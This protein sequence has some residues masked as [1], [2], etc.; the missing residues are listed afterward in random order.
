MKA[1]RI[2]S[3]KCPCFIV[4]ILVLGLVVPSIP[5]FA[6][7]DNINKEIQAKIKTM[8]LDTINTVIGEKKGRRIS[9]TPANLSTVAQMF[10]IEQG[11][12]IGVME[13]ELAGD[14]SSLP[15]GKFVIYLKKEFGQWKGYAAANGQVVAEAARV[16]VE[17]KF[18]KD[19]N[20]PQFIAEGFGFRL[21]LNS[22]LIMFFF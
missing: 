6:A 7:W 19:T 11:Q 18:N 15:P 3:I 14:E 20:K 16:T 9:F 22:I 5:S 21:P 1:K 8:N 13:T 2:K 4:L 10:D 17:Q 12:V